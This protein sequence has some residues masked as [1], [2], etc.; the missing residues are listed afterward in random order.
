MQTVFDLLL[1]GN[2]N[3]EGISNEGNSNV[4]GVIQTIYIWGL[5]AILVMLIIFKKF[6][7]ALGVLVMGAILGVF[8]YGP[9]NIVSL[10][11][12]VLKFLGIMS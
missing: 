5:L 7:A 12:S 6:R 2:V 11:E 4:L 8:I 1:L 9:D 10:G 3:L